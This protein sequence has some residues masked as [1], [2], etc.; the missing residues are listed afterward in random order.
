MQDTHFESNH[1][2]SGGAIQIGQLSGI[3]F[4]YYRKFIVCN[5]LLEESLQRGVFE[6]Q[7]A[8]F[9]GN[10]ATQGGAFAIFTPGTRINV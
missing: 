3:C 1:A 7:H 2:Q 6:V 4:F 10:G 9:I 8:Q 5:D